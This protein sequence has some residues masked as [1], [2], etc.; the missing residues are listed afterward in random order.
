M[1]LFMFKYKITKTKVVRISQCL[2]Y[3]IQILTREL[4]FDFYFPH[5]HWVPY[6]YTDHTGHVIQTT[7]MQE[8]FFRYNLGRG[9]KEGNFRLCFCVIGE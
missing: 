6:N 2:G 5:R 4:D 7:V 3:E 8:L 9:R 1:L